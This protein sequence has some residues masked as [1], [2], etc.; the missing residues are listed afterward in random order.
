MAMFALSYI[1]GLDVRDVWP[2][3][4][5]KSSDQVANMK[6]RG[7]LPA[8]FTADLKDQFD[9]KLCPPFLETKFDFQDDEEDQLKA[10]NR[11]IR[12]RM[13]SR[14]AEVGAVDTEA[15]R[16]IMLEAGDI[17]REEFIR[18]QLANGKLEDGSPIAVLFH[19]DDKIMKPL[20]TLSGIEDPLVYEDN[21]KESAIREIHIQQS[22]ALELLASAPSMAQTKRALSVL[23]ALD[24][25][26]EEYGKLQRREEMLSEEEESAEEGQEEG[27]EEEG[28]EGEEDERD[29][30]QQ[31]EEV[32]VEQ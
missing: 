31:E 24:W 14:L 10:N 13:V 25:L 6:A 3:Q 8:D 15:Q 11:D 17:S 28:E 26:E 1:W 19:T 4:G 16:R 12:S 32:A 5:A 23:A 20:L 21:D 7:R 9:L 30:E 2:I 27:Q 29:E 22:A 18:Q